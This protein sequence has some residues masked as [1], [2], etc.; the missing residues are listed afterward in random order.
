MLSEPSNG[1]LIKA[2]SLFSKVEPFYSL[3]SQAVCGSH[4]PVCV[5]QTLPLMEKKLIVLRASAFSVHDCS[6]LDS[7]IN[8]VNSS[9]LSHTAAALNH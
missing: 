7:S 5:P 6:V 2:Q 4:R 1:T 9:L 3:H 8:V